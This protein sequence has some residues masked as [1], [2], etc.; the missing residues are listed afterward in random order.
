MNFIPMKNLIYCL[1]IAF[2]FLQACNNK[3]TSN[4]E[5]NTNKITAKE[6]IKGNTY[7][8]I[9]GSNGKKNIWVAIRNQPIEKNKTYYFTEAL[10]MKNFHSKELDRKFA[11]ILFLNSISDQPLKAKKASMPMH[12]SPKM[13]NPAKRIEVSMESK[14]GVTSLSDLFSHKE[15]YNGKEIVVHGKVAKFNTN[16]LGKNWVHIQD[17]TE[18]DGEFDLTITTNTSTSVGELVEYRGIITLNKD[19]GAGYTYDII[20]ENATSTK[21]EQH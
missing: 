17:G 1:S 7:T 16:I 6:V 12:T 3:K 18:H 5:I 10:E 14:D 13:K 8:Y 19:F 9:N 11:S 15:K 21:T 20:M 4:E 2:L